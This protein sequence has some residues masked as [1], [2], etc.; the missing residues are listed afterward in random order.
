MVGNRT[1]TRPLIAKDDAEKADVSIR[2]DET[3]SPTE[4]KT[5]FCR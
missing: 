5:H 3:A 2:P 1:E 4:C